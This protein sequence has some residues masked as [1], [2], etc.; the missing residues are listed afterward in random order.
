MTFARDLMSVESWMVVIWIMLF[1]E[2]RTLVFHVLNAL[3]WNWNWNYYIYI[4]CG[5][6]VACWPLVPKFAGSNPPESVGILRAKK[7]SARLPSEGSVKPSVPC[8]RFA[9]CKRSLNVVE[10]VISGRWSRH[11]GK[12]TGQNSRPQFHLPPLG[13]LTDVEA[14][15]GESGNV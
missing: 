3:N 12:S 13:S 5:L 15:G 2:S 9:A 1:S 8:R 11:F 4:Y 14:S 6:E 10:V 7:S